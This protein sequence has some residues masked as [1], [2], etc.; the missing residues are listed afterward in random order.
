MSPSQ[1]R[2]SKWTAP[3]GLPIVPSSGAVLADGKVLFWAADG[4][5]SFGGNGHTFSALFDPVANTAI[6]RDVADTGHDMFCAG[7]ARLADG[8][9]LVNGG[10]DAGATSVYDPLNNT[11]QRA[12]TMNIARGY[13]ASATLADGSVLTL[14]G[15]W[16]GGDGNK[17]AEIYTPESGWRT[18]GGVPQDP[19]LLY[20]SYMGWQSDS[21]PALV[22][23][24]NGKVLMAGPAVDMAWIDTR[25][26][27]SSTPAGRRGDDTPSF[28]GNT[29]MYEAGKILKVGG[30]GWNN[31]EPANARAY[32]IDT[33]S[34]SADVRKLAP[35]AYPR[36]FSNSVVLPNGQVLVVGGQTYAQEF[37]DSNAVLAP[38]LFDPQTQTF[39]VLPSMSV[40][41]NYHSIALLMPDARVISAGGGMCNCDADHPDLQIMSPPYLFNEDGSAAT[42]PVIV[43]A[44]ARLSYGGEVTVTTTAAVTSFSLV[45][46]GSITHTVDSGQRR[47]SLGFSAADATHYQ[48]SIPS[49]PGI[50]IPGQWMLFAMDAQG[51]PSVAKIVTV[52][53][54]GAPVLQNPGNMNVTVGQSM[55]LQATATTAVGALDFG[56]NGLPAG[57]RM[58][59]GTGLISGT[60]T[61]PGSF[62]ATIFVGNKTQTVSTDIVIHV[63]QIGSGTGLLAQYFANTSLSGPPVLQ[64]T[65]APN[66]DWGGSAPAPGV[67]A[68]RFSTRWSGWIEAPS[69]GRTGVRTVSDDGVRVWVGDWLVIDNWTDHGPTADTATVVMEGGRR[70]PI[71]VEYMESTGGAT[72]QLQWQPAG[73]TDYVPV[74][75]ERLYPGAPPALNN[76]AL[77]QPSSQASTNYDA[78]SSRAVDGNTN[79]DWRAG[80]LTESANTG[81][82]DWWQVDLGRLSR[83]DRVQLWNRTDCCSERLSNFMVF[84]SPNDM[85]GRTL[86]QL[87]S[88]PAVTSR[89]VGGTRALPN[90]GIPVGGLGRYVRVQLVGNGVLSLAEVEVFGGPVVYHTPTVDPIGDQQGLAGTA[91]SLTVKSSDPDGNRLSYSATGLPTGLRLH[92]DTGVISGSF[93]APGSYSVSVTAGNGGGLSASVAFTWTVLGV[94]PKVTSLPAPI[95]TSGA[96]VTYTPAL[97]A[98][99][100]AEYS[101]NFGDGTG[102]AAFAGSA[103]VNH[104][105]A[106][107]GAY[108][109]TLTI[110]TGD[111]RYAIE[112]FV[113]G[114]SA[115][116]PTAAARAS[117]N[118]L[119]EPRAGGGA[120]RL[121][122]VNEDNDSVSVFDTATDTRLAEIAVGS[123]P[124]SLALL[125]DGRVWVVN[126]QS[127]S[128][129]IVNPAT[130]AVVQT[131]ALPRASQPFGIVVSPADGSAFVTLEATGQV[132]QLNAGSGA[133][134]ARVPVGDNPR[135]L[136]ITSS[137]E[138]LLVSRYI[139]PPLPGEGTAS[140]RTTDANNVRVGG[141]VVIVDT[142]SLTVTR[143]VVLGHSEVPDAENQGRGIPNYLGAPAIAPDGA[144]AWIPSKQ[145]NVLR[146]LLR[147]GRDLDFQNTVRAVSSRI[148]LVRGSE[149]LASRIDHDNASVASAAVYHPSGVYLFVALETSR[150]VAVIDSIGRKEL[151]RLDVG[152]AP[153]GLAVSADGLRLYVSNLLGRSVSA[154][155]LSPLVNSGRI[156]ASTTATLATVATERLSP[157]VLRGKQLFYD[158]R[159]PRLAR[160]SYM[161]CASCHNDGG[162]D[163]R[164]WDLTGLGEGLRNTIALRGRAGLRHGFLHWSANFDEVQ[165][166][167]G[168]IRQLA[169]GTGLMLDADFNA[170][171]RSQPLGD[172]KA[173]RSADLDALAA[174]IG[175]LDAFA[176]SPWRNPDATLTPT[177]QL[178][179]AVFADN[180]C[181]SCHGGTGFTG[182]LDAGQ[183]KNIGTL[184]P[185]SGKRLGGTLVGIDIPTL[186]D[187]WASAPY[188][189][190]GSAPTLGAAVQAHNGVTLSADDLRGLTEYLRQIGSDEIVPPTAPP[191]TPVPPP[192]PPVPPPPPPVPPPPAPVPP[193]S[194]PSVVCANEGGTCH[195]PDGAV[196]TV[197]Y[198]ANGA[199]ASRQGVSGS[200]DCTN[201]VFG[202]PIYGVVKSCSYKLTLLPPTA[203]AD[204]GGTCNLP[205]GAVATVK[206][207]ANGIFVS[208]QGVSGSVACTN[209]VFGDPIVFVVKSCTYQVTGPI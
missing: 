89:Q 155:D 29:V 80:S 58:D 162:Q 47:V 37:S 75:V 182:S 110:R 18:L 40:P 22:P 134:L 159:D 203:C 10:L 12:A 207:G 140:V 97:S 20:G 83:I 197:T 139:T 128:I 39:T 164:T 76:I 132:L 99:V 62:L 82:N 73:A 129:S 66:F 26:N 7:T 174:Y 194:A 88:D 53:N 15:S 101:W 193:P 201:A 183:L 161:S 24:A 28:S 77:G 94:V 151:F 38:E 204:E 145:D 9:L 1:A 46:L 116:G 195:V 71:T 192:P 113:Q 35:M 57:L 130:L 187:V 23:T 188:L 50:L 32:V 121:W 55:T 52:D 69:S 142:A 91:A 36:V 106:S 48:V 2:L 96:A 137:G 160:D 169:G 175:S 63:S 198:G 114:I 119:L 43:D 176:P 167:E 86:D 171:S 189:H 81:P 166:F 199:Y 19:Y 56:A 78:V 67:P 33:T 49:N 191:A 200:V 208:R 87:R 184:K 202:D 111:G 30:A 152:L 105:Y 177:A 102:D 60:P 93:T 104:R 16:S 6:E 178:G 186:R 118:L 206:Y 120:A 154:I 209:D 45:R 95:A 163:G 41:R 84:V 124:R 21:H 54:T 117:S 70:Y 3:V 4:R 112:R 14:G 123:A 135:H 44:P 85:T 168:Q 72:L 205:A 179:K 185:G 59:R 74:P 90:I 8:R 126:K 196:A 143:T 51:T 146:G 125:P 17:T 157:S 170:G 107:P 42:R 149:D 158:A 68:D 108:S 172:T 92:P 147:D 144:T 79:G 65:E 156:G 27:G 181:A 153:Q 34:G 115:S 11:W 150:Q 180:N 138:R 61:A 133:V 173:G 141:E 131:L 109:V 64:R 165:D 25:G 103:A 100:S 5:R 31:N 122:V 98:G 148:D 190:D 136:A 127:A 13:N